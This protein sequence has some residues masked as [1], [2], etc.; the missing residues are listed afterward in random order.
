MMSIRPATARRRETAARAASGATL[1]VLVWLGADALYVP[2]ITGIRPSYPFVAAAG[3]G[4][5]VAALSARRGLR[6]LSAVAALVA[7]GVLFV[8][9]L[10][11]AP[12]LAR[13]L[14]R[15]DRP[16][17][18]AGA[19]V[20]AVAVLSDG[21]GEDGLLEGQGLDRLL[22]GA[23]LARRAAR[24]LIISVVHPVRE[25]QASSLADQRRVVDLVSPTPQLWIV[26][27]VHSTHDEAVR[28]TAVA[29]GQGWRRVA[30]VTSPAHT[31]RACATFERAGLPVV[32]TPAP[33]RDASWGGPRPLRSAGDRLR[34]AG[35]WLYETL[36][37][38]AY[39]ARGWV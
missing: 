31:R 30:L 9:A 14:V 19:P 18:E 10:P 32:C 38:I 21:I 27:D 23:A 20:D 6:A 3:V 11:V 22:A 4:A 37:W 5:L 15:Q 2:Q 1:G 8:T 28:M 24:P 16:T 12:A 33:A 26:D 36:G 29:R 25:P 39:R 34:T 13:G 35:Q 17:V 7:L